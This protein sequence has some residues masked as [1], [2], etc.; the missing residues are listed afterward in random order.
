MSRLEYTAYKKDGMLKIRN[1][2]QMDTDVKELG[3]GEYEMIIQRKRRIRSIQINRYY[4]GVVV[5]LIRDRFVDLGNDVSKE[6][7][8]DFLKQR[9][10]YKELVDKS[11]GEVIQIGQSTANMTNTEFMVYMERIKEFASSV[12][13]I[14]IPEPNTQAAMDFSTRD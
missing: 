11:G 12:L 4:W 1:R 2:K 5:Q 8:H 6:D 7:T 9:F 10:N 3:D 13:S 14:V